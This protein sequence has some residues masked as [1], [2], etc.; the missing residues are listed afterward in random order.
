[1]TANDP[2]SEDRNDGSGSAGGG[3][4]RGG[5][6]LRRYDD[7]G[8]ANHLSAIRSRAREIMF[9]FNIP[10]GHICE[11]ARHAEER[12]TDTALRALFLHTLIDVSEFGREAKRRGIG[13]AEKGES[14]AAQP[15]ADRPR[16]ETRLFAPITG[17]SDDVSDGASRDFFASL[18]APKRPDR[19]TAPKRRPT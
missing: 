11:M 3:H 8:I 6:Y 10:M 4:A 5:D 14:A 9:E 1:M 13:V 7:D 15:E 18:D 16:P 19:P 2:K 17:A 12:I